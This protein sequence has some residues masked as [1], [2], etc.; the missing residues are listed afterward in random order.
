M[1][2]LGSLESVR[3]R[4][5]LLMRESS[6]KGIVILAAEGFNSTVCGPATNISAFAEAAERILDSEIR[7]KST[8]HHENPFRRVDVKI[9]P[10]IVT[11]KKHVNTVSESGTHVPPER[12]NEIISD[13][14]TTII[15]ARNDYEFRTG[16]F[17][18][19][20]NPGT[21]RFSELPDF[22]EANLDPE[23][24]KKIAT[25]CT[26]GVRCEKFVP[27]LKSL[28]FDEVYQLD[29]GV[30]R[31]LEEIPPADSLWEGECFVFDSRVSVDEK[32]Q[33]GESEDL[34][35]AAAISSRKLPVV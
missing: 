1:T 6:I 3:D 13:P 17:Q 8:F 25:F 12:W 10:E 11:F 19:A 34:S 4:L 23:R 30:L 21:A 29:G 5:R 7:F 20:I 16:T 31:Y 24:H 15:D 33:K 14:A 32:L 9:K 2:A 28:G 27:Y 22:V 35:L 26:G 18:R